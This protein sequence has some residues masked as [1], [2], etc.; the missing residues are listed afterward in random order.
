MWMVENGWKQIKM[1]T[2]T[3]NIAEACSVCSMRID[4][5]LRHNV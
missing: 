2:M 3:E 1:K 4:F 5:N